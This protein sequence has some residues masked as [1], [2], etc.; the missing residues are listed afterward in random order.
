MSKYEPL[1][2]FLRHRRR[3]DDLTLTFFE[4]ERIIGAPLPKA[5]GKAEWWSNAAP[6]DRYEVQRNAW[7][8]A[9]YHAVPGSKEAV[10]FR[11][12]DTSPRPEATLSGRRRRLLSCL[13][14]RSAFGGEAPE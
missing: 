12:A 13:E 10:T 8:D 4:I 9:G 6:K 2:R 3:D 7:L 11:R 5:V 14:A 1:R